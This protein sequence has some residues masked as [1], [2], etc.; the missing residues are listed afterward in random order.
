[1]HASADDIINVIKRR[2]WASNCRENIVMAGN[3]H[4]IWVLSTPSL[5]FNGQ[6]LIFKPSFTIILPLI[7]FSSYLDLED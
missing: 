2:N 1:M 7:S 5:N 4:L 3:Y 6:E